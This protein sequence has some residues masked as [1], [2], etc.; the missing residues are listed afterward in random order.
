MI[1]ALVFPVPRDLMLPLPLPEMLL[2]ILLVVFFLAH[3]LFINLVVGGSLWTLIFE[4][5]GLK[6]P[7]YDRLAK[8]I[9]A[10]ITVNKS[11]AVVLGVGP[12]L[13]ISLVY[14]HAFYTA[15]VLTA[16]AWWS[17]VPD[18]HGGLSADLSA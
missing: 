3:I 13:C 6:H 15:N 9:A 7:R 12:L 18:H 5:L 11:L 8:E 16:H 10:T 17:L 1:S 4:W 14:T 2:K